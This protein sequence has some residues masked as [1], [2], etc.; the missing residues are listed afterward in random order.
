MEL[1]QFIRVLRLRSDSFVIA[2]VI[3]LKQIKFG[4]TEV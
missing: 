2:I 4:K 3:K 1:I